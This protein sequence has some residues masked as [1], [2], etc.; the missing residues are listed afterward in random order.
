MDDLLQGP[1]LAITVGNSRTR[2]GLFL[3]GDLS[4]AVSVANPPAA[5]KD[6]TPILREAQRL[7]ADQHAAP[8]VISS[9]RKPLSD[10]LTLEL[11]G[12]GDVFAIG[13]DIPVPLRHNLDDAT[14]LGQDRQL[15]AFAAYSRAQQACVVVDAGTAITVDFVDGEGVFQGG[16]IAPGLAM[17]LASLHEKTS[18]L[19]SL[20][21]SPPVPDRGPFGKD[22]RHAMLLG[23]QAAA[24]GLV[25]HIVETYAEAYEAY[26]QI[27]AT[28]G[29]AAALFEGDEV[30]E[31]IVPDLQLIGVLE[32]CK[33]AAG[34]VEGEE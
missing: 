18:A 25:R 19:P 26:P 32:A 29:D 11:E 28:G 20:A 17:M 27:V 9:V 3:K 2:L 30:V 15:C 5:S 33:A 10:A 23:V 6:F 16:V 31:H 4:N 1:L 24:R 21:W 12:L 13:Q 22:T 7:L 8:V 14:T 34:E